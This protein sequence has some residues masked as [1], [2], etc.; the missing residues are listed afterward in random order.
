MN[1]QA[2]WSPADG[3]T[4]CEVAFENGSMRVDLD[5]P[6]GDV[7]LPS[8]HDVLHAALAACTTLTLQLYVKRKGWAVERLQVEVGHAAPAAGD[9]SRAYAIERTVRVAG[10]LDDAQRASL[11]RIAEACP[12]HKTLVGEITVATRVETAR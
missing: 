11:L 8:P 7:E 10:T 6:Q 9:S 3:R 1:V 5:P 12:I 4:A 2:S